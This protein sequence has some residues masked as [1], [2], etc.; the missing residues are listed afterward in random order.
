MKRQ[1]SRLLRLRRSSLPA[2]EAA[3]HGQPDSR[4]GPNNANMPQCLLLPELLDVIFDFVSDRSTLVSLAR[5]C[6]HFHAVAAD[7]IPRHLAHV[8]ELLMCLPHNL[9][10]LKLREQYNELGYMASMGTHSKPWV[11][12]FVREMTS[13]DWR[14]FI[15]KASK[16]KTIGIGDCIKE[17]DDHWMRL[18]LGYEYYPELHYPW[19][20][21]RPVTIGSS[22]KKAFVSAK[23]IPILFPNLR[24]LRGPMPRYMLPKAPP[25]HLDDVDAI[26]LEDAL[27]Y[28]QK[29]PSLPSGCPNL[30]AFTFT[31]DPPF[32]HQRPLD[33]HRLFPLYISKWDHLRSYTG[34]VDVQMLLHLG[35]FT[36][37]DDLNLLLNSHICLDEFRSLPLPSSR[38]LLRLSSLKF[39]TSCCSE[40]A[41]ALRILF[42]SFED[43]PSSHQPPTLRHFAMLGQFD[44]TSFSK[45]GLL[46]ANTVSVDSLETFCISD[47]REGYVYSL[48]MVT[49]SRKSVYETLRP[50]CVFPNLTGIQF[51]LTTGHQVKN[52]RLTAAQ[53]IE[54]ASAWPELREFRI[55]KP[56]VEFTLLEAAALRRRCP[57]LQTIPYSSI[58]TDKH[59]VA[60]LAADPGLLERVLGSDVRITSVEGAP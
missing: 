7:K 16:V 45:M 36:D 50:L 51:P 1:L 4:R 21:G 9:W 40:V 3:F 17:E 5:V 34:P 38:P 15:S 27:D 42:R 32:L 6:S 48:R 13:N 44:T 20:R 49:A 19:Y 24:A 8:Y 57:R 30:R 53:L 12:S 18:F 29:R 2:P 39:R 10:E 35:H 43:I 52:G 26:S 54:L 56:G 23:C 33:Y 47:M 55:A 11:L 31:P 59:D 46:L 41:N 22:I 58:R 14:I 60:A 37:L 25:T 28:D